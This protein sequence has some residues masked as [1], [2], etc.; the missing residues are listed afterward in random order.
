M[1]D[2]NEL[3]MTHGSGEGSLQQTTSPGEIYSLENALEN[4]ADQKFG[5]RL[6]WRPNGGNN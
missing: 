1:P 3:T 4:L 5:E 6:A 2:F